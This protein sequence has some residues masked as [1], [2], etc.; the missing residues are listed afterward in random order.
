MHD[1]LHDWPDDDAKRIV[2]VVKSAVKT[3]VSKLLSEEKVV[4]DIK[5]D[6][7]HTSLDRC[8]TNVNLTESTDV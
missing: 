6:V 3:S 1:V 2:E 5:G 8:D 4:T 7:L